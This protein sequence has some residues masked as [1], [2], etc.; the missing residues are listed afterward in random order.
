M[1]N[2]YREHSVD[3]PYIKKNYKD[4]LRKMETAGK[5]AAEPPANKRRLYKGEVTFG[6]NTRVI[7]PVR[8]NKYG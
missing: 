2:I 7:F 8:S 6:D 5:I 3:K 4:L 1:Q